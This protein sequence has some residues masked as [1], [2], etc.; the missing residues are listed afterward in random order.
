MVLES[1]LGRNR[2]Q[3]PQSSML[4]PLQFLVPRSSESPS[5]DRHLTGIPIYDSA[6]ED[7][8]VNYLPSP[9]FLI[10]CHS[11]SMGFNG[12]V[13]IPKSLALL[14]KSPNFILVPISSV[15]VGSEDSFEILLLYPNRVMC[16]PYGKC[17]N[18]KRI[19]GGLTVVSIVNAKCP[20]I[21]EV[22][23]PRV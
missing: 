7:I 12:P 19:K 20:I 3:A 1:Q 9:F 4:R 14:T 15:F 21:P 16:I 6:A 13:A 17:R 11:A 10:N 5:S 18:V 8:S 2:R 23:N 22:G